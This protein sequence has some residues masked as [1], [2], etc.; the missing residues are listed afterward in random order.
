M[1]H[2]P[3]KKEKILV[4]SL[5]SIFG[6][7]MLLFGGVL[8][9]SEIIFPRHFQEKVCATLSSGTKA[10]AQDI[11]RFFKNESVEDYQIFL[12]TPGEDKVW[13]LNSSASIELLNKSKVG[14]PI[15]ILASMGVFKKFG[16]EVTIENQEIQK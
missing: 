7:C 3:I 6:V 9:Y 8:V 1:E 4:Y 13:P 16:C 5:I 10:S 14:Y 15:K 12:T 11:I 2:E